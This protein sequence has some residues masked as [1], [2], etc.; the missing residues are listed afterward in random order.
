MKNF[1]LLANFQTTF[2]LLRIF[3]LFI[4]IYVFLK[5]PRVFK[6]PIFSPQV[7]YQN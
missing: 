2:C 5:F 6:V 3:L 7:T 1:V 4:G